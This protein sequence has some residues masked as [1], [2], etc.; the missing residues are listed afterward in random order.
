M[1]SAVANWLTLH[2]CVS[3]LTVQLGGKAGNARELTAEERKRKRTNARNNSQ[4][5]KDKALTKTAKQYSKFKTWLS[6]LDTYK[7][8]GV[9]VLLWALTQH[10]LTRCCAAGAACV[11]AA[12]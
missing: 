12:M 7:Q 8:R 1:S 9:V 6:G 11:C 3:S 5:Q 10:G 2:G 4:H